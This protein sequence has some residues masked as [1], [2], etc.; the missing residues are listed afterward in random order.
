MKN[1]IAGSNGRLPKLIKGCIHFVTA[2]KM[3]KCPNGVGTDDEPCMI[4]RMP[5]AAKHV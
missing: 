4:P 5:P 1:A 2:W 3:S